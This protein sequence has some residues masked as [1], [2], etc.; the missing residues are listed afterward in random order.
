MEVEKGDRPFGEI[1]D[2]TNIRLKMSEVNA[3]GN[4]TVVSRPMDAPEFVSLVLA[5]YEKN[6]R[7]QR[8]AFVNADVQA[9]YLLGVEKDPKKYLANL[10]ADI[11]RD[12]KRVEE[13][14]MSFDVKQ[15]VIR[16]VT[17]E[18]A[19]PFDDNDDPAWHAINYI[20]HKQ[21]KDSYDIDGNV[22]SRS[23]VIG[24]FMMFCK[25]TGISWSFSKFMSI[26]SQ[27]CYSAS[28]GLP[29]EAFRIWCQN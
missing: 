7:K 28:F 18:Y 11:D 5:E 12:T 13:I 27:S 19:L 23:N 14:P 24:H 25:V 29:P 8:A 21:V 3:N 20:P 10:K 26:M 15:E 6:A 22:Y 17:R 4:F 16:E 2:L 1:I 9:D